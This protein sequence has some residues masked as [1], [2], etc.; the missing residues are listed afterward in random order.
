MLT[1]L[2]NN[3]QDTL[4]AGLKQVFANLAKDGFKR[5]YNH[6]DQQTIKRG[7]DEMG[8]D[9][10]VNQ[11]ALLA[12]GSGAVTGVGGFATM[13]V[14]VPLD[15]TNLIAQQFRVTLAVNYYKTGRSKVS[16]LELL[17]IVASSLSVDAGLAVSKRVVEEVASKLLLVLG[18]KS[19]RR[20]VPVVGA[21]I[22]GSTNYM[23]IKKVARDL[24]AKQDYTGY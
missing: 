18:S 19:A 2:P 5:I 17:G 13:L 12:A 20:L 9:K 4:K 7:V 8:I 23:F 24:L 21:V 10:F 11:C 1:I 6:I 22:G 3:K 15:M 14:G 16:F